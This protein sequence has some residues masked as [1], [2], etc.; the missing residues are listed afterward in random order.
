MKKTIRRQAVDILNSVAQGQAFAGDL[1]DLALN[2]QNLSGQANGRLLTHLVYGVLRQQGELDWI[3]GQFYRGNYTQMD[4]KVKNI[5]RTGIFQLRFSDR[6]PPFAVVDE[7]VKISKQITPAAG[8]LINAILRNYLRSSQNISFP[9]PES[10]LALFL[11]TRYS[12]PLWL[13]KV[14]LDCF[15]AKETAELCQANNELP[16]VTLRVN[17]LKISRPQLL[18]KLQTS[19]FHCA[20][21]SYSPDGITLAQ[22]PHPAQKTAF[23]QEGLFR[24]QD[25]AAQLSSFLVNPEKG[26][27]VLD[28]C[29][30]SGGKTTHL[31]ALMKNEGHI[32][33]LERNSEKIAELNK[34]ASRMG[35][36]IIESKQ[37]DLLWPLPAKWTECFDF[38]LADVPCCGTGTF[39]RNPE[40]KWRLKAENIEELSRKQQTILQNAAKAVKKCGRLIYCA[41]SLSPSENEQVIWQF[42]AGHPEFCIEA[43]SCAF[44]GNLLNQHGFFQTSPSRH[45]MDGFFGA[46]LRRGI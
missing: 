12:H 34:E 11:S 7:A 30:G 25:E 43:P 35:I 4:E 22:S 24:I 42:L 16:P 8:G 21:T 26:G 15:G 45:A 10:N 39:R 46:V 27:L 20:P 29:A 19:Q 41:C 9:S 31:A 13:V 14:W 40:I 1:L 18:K 3:I 38:V 44:L 5:L 28:A 33:A 36:S 17:T 32:L 37:A 23:F 2:Q 6:L